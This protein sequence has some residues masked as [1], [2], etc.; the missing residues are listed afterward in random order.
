VVGREARNQ[1]LGG[2][3]RLVSIRKVSSN[4]IKAFKLRRTIAE[5]KQA[6]LS[7]GL[8]ILESRGAEDERIVK[9]FASQPSPLE[10]STP[11][12]LGAQFLSDSPPIREDR[13]AFLFGE[14]KPTWNSSF[15]KGGL[16]ESGRKSR[17]RPWSGSSETP[18]C[19]LEK[20]TRCLGGENAYNDDAVRPPG[21]PEEI[22]KGGRG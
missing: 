11:K 2:P 19:L 10:I 8:S 3:R 12:P 17:A 4:T 9:R 6:R 13:T 7:V 18:V 5:T 14:A 20:E 1:G 16:N 21:N 15:G 22:Q